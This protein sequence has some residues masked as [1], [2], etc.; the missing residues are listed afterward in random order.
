M[1]LLFQITFF[2]A[3]MVVSART[4]MDGRNACLPCIRALDFYADNVSDTN[5]AC[6]KIGKKEKCS[7]RSTIRSADLLTAVTNPKRQEE[8]KAREAIDKLS[9]H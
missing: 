9:K 7:Q 2:A 6:L 4:Q 3:L 5:K 1:K 8:L